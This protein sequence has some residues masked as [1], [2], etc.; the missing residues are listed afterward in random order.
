MGEQMSKSKF[1]LIIILIIIASALNAKDIA[2]TRALGF[3]LGTASGNGYAYRLFKG[4][5]GFQLVF[6]AMTIGDDDVKFSDTIYRYEGL[7]TESVTKK[8]RRTGASVGLSYINVL[9]ETL[10]SRFYVTAGASYLYSRRTDFTQEYIESTGS[11][12]S[13]VK[14]GV[15]TESKKN[16]DRWTLGVGPGMEL[17]IDR[18][19]RVSLELPITI[20]S[21]SEVV[22]YIPQVG[23]Y[24][25]FK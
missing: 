4:D 3:H 25:Y 7:E 1:I 17:Y 20:N 23:I 6:G 13:Y 2:A 11:S 5:N 19:L 24:F 8:G 22:P 16:S 21:K 12:S 15:P 9:V 18:N 14:S 10:H